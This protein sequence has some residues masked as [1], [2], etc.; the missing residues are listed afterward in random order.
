M[1]AGS[2]EEAGSVGRRGLRGRRGLWGRGL[3]G[4]FSGVEYGL[5]G[6]PGPWKGRT[7]VRGGAYGEVWSVRG[8]GPLCKHV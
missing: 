6:V 3:G 7:R 8:L 2:V 5:W 1:G 4:A